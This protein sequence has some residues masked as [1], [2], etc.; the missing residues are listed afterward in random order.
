MKSE[1]EPEML[2]SVQFPLATTLNANVFLSVFCE[3]KNDL[4]SNWKKYSKKQQI[5]AVHFFISV[6]CIV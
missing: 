6:R 1:F 5:F 4:S 3:K 2:N